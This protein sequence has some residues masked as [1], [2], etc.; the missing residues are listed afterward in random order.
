MIIADDT[1]GFDA[2]TDQEVDQN[3]F[4]FGLA[5]FQVIAGNKNTFLFGQI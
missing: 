4:Q 5:W 1:D 2:R 3:T